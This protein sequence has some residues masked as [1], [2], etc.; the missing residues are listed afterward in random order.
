MQPALASLELAQHF[1]LGEGIEAVPD[2]FVQ[3]KV[4]IEAALDAELAVLLIPGRIPQ[5]Y[6]INA[7]AVSSTQ[8]G[9]TSL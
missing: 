5:R 4:R 9:N 7:V 1:L 2:I 3:G 6:L 8:S